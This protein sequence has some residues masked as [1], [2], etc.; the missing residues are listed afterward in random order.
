MIDMNGII[1]KPQQGPQEMFLSSPADICIYG[2][3]AGGG[4]TYG[5]LLE[6]LRHLENSEFGAVIFRKNSNQIFSEGGLW[7]TSYKVYPLVNGDPKKTPSPMWTFDSGAKVTF[8]HMDR[9][10]DVLKWQG[11]QIALIGFDE[12][13]HFSKNQFFYMLSRN[14]STCGIRPY[15][16]ATCNPDCDSWVAEFISWWIDQ[17]TGYPIPERSGV[18]RFMTQLNDTLYWGATP[19]EVV[20]QAMGQMAIED[21]KSVTFIAS[22]LTDNKILMENDPG[23]MANLKALSTVERERLL[24][25]NWKIRPAAGLYFHRARVNMLEEIPTDVFAWVRAWDLAATEDRKGTRPED[26]PAY[27]ACVLMGKRKNGRYIVADVIN[28]RMNSSDVRR[29]VLNTAILDK[30]KYG[31]KVRIR[32]NQDPGQAGKDQAEQYLKLL[33]GFSVNIERES[34]DKVTRFEP[35]SAQALGISGSE[36]GNVDILIAP[37]NDADFSQLES[38]PDSRFKDMADASGTAFNELSN[39]KNLSLPPGTAMTADRASPWSI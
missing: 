16:R 39:I 30:A 6:P 29:T 17:E 37:W 10:K 32:M 9:E 31:R 5:L 38:F 2:G 18:I 27:T 1:L 7:D 33:Q 8:A 3:A 14:R 4:K 25:G 28:R 24:E 15:V 23:Y 13:T 35:F 19:S 22:K 26:G 36:A 20:E 34:G 12:L 21:V 11:S